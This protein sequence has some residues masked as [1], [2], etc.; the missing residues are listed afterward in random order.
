MIAYAAPP[1]ADVGLPAVIEIPRANNMSYPGRDPGL[2]GPRYGRWG[3]DIAPKCNAKDAAGSCPNCF[4]H[5]DP[6]DPDAVPRSR[7]EC[8]VGQ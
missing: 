1:R 5:D 3:V 2:L 8:L 7:S 4:S 6:N